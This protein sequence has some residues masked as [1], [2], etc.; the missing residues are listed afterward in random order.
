MQYSFLLHI[1]EV[2][3]M[4]LDYAEYC[5]TLLLYFFST[6]KLA[7]QLILVSYANSAYLTAVGYVPYCQSTESQYGSSLVSQGPR[8]GGHSCSFLNFFYRGF[9][10]RRLYWCLVWYV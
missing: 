1:P 10:T 3:E 4:R 2:L 6:C 8:G 5:T 9:S 7:L